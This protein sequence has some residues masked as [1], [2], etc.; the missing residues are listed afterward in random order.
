[1][2][3]ALSRPKCLVAALVAALLVTGTAFAKDSLQAGVTIPAGQPVPVM[4]EN[5]GGYTPG[6]YAVGTIHL[7]YVYVGTS[8]PQGSFATFNLN[9]SVYKP[10][11]TGAEPTYPVS[12]DLSNA[13]GANLALV[14]SVSPVAATGVG[15]S[16]V[17]PVDIVIPGDIAS[18]ADWDDDGDQLVGKLQLSS[19]TGSK[20]DTVTT[21]IVKITLVHPSACLKVYNFITDAAFSETI[22][23]TEVNVNRRGTVVATNPYGSLSSN[24]VVVNTCS[25]VENFDLRV[26]LD[27]WFSTQPSNNPGNA[28]FTFAA[29]GEIDPAAF[30]IASFGLGTPQ[31]QNLCLG[32]VAVPGGGTFLT[33]VHMAINNVAASG[34][35]SD[36]KFDDFRATLYGA[37]TACSG[38]PV[39]YA[40][41]NPAAAALTFTKK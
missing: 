29:S 23:A 11:A 14:P 40:A 4:T 6:T 26:V 7:N 8:F 19:E 24:V 39:G 18:S 12:V 36:G 16:A 32:T 30:N 17:V 34:L 2:F 27:P 21:V 28:V 9:L 38:S 3:T 20:L 10:S 33:T 41:P 13:G 35:P 5:G 15:W 25:S 1:M 31:G 37:G 22:T